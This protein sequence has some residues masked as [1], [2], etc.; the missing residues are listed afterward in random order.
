MLVSW[1][2][3]TTTLYL[4]IFFIPYG[5]N[6]SVIDIIYRISYIFVEIFM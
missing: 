4:N 6:I 2:V 1:R 3:L 5:P